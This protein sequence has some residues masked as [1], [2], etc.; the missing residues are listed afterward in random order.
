M[1]HTRMM[2]DGLPLAWEHDTFM[3]GEDQEIPMDMGLEVPKGKFVTVRKSYLWKGA[4]IS[5]GMVFTMGVAIGGWTESRYFSPSTTSQSLKTTSLDSEPKSAWISTAGTGEIHPR[6]D[7]RALSAAEFFQTPKFSST[8]ADKLAVLHNEFHGKSGMYSDPEE[9]QHARHAAALEISSFIGNLSMS[10]PQA[11]MLLHNIK[12]DGSQQD[13]TYNILDHFSDLNT[14]KVGAEVIEASIQGMLE[15]RSGM[16][17]RLQEKFGPHLDA[18][19]RIKNDIFPDDFNVEQ[20]SGKELVD[21]EDDTSGNQAHMQMLTQS[22][23]GEDLKSIT[24]LKNHLVNMQKEAGRRLMPAWGIV[25]MIAT[26]VSTV[27]CTLLSVVI[28]GKAGA[29]TIM[30]IKDVIAIVTCAQWSLAPLNWIGCVV[31]LLNAVLI[32]IFTFV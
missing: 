2:S 31:N 14:Q 29:L 10:H 12:L 13:V 19:R 18:L 5:A 15:G 16:K 28:P 1:A 23:G 21:P 9:M 30:S 27:I 26:V 4:L 24:A 3:E 22:A 11:A 6:A 17:R 7:P 25:N 8:L 32:T 20:K